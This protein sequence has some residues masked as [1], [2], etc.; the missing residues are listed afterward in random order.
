MEEL[1]RLAKQYYKDTIR[2]KY[3]G[4]EGLFLIILSLP[5]LFLSI[6]LNFKQNVGNASTLPLGVAAFF[7][8]FAKAQY[9]KNL[10]IYLAKYTQI[11]SK[12]IK[13]H[14]AHYLQNITGHIS[15]TLFDTLKVFK[16]ILETESRNRPF[17]LDNMGHYFS[18]FLYDPEAKSRI[19]SLSIYLISLVAIL[20]VVKPNTDFNVYDIIESLTWAGLLTYF[21]ICF[22]I[23]LFCYFLAIIPLMFVTTYILTPF[24]LK[25]SNVYYLNRFFINEL[26]RYSFSEYKDIHKLT[27]SLTESSKK[28]WTGSRPSTFEKP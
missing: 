3:F 6:W 2:L 17:V 12:D 1:K 27:K 28:C 21:S 11:D 15:P 18:K 7:W 20:T 14:K 26:N 22:V 25:M 16:E 24:L 9:D 13:I 4:F 19:L 23:I 8:F 10:V 5:F